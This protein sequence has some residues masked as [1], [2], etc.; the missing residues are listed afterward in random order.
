MRT[1]RQL[2]AA[3]RGARGPGR[4]GETTGGSL[5]RAKTAPSI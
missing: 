4:R 3:Q 1:N 5:V 2:S